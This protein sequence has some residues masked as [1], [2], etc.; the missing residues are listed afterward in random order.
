[1][2]CLALKDKPHFR[3]S[4]VDLDRESPSFTADTLRAIKEEYGC[5][6]RL[7]F[8]MGMDSLENLR[9]WHHPEDIIRLT[10]IIAVSRP[11]FNAD[12]ATLERDLPGISGVT[13]TLTT[14]NIGISSTD[15][16]RRVKQGLSIDGQVPAS[17]GAYIDEYHLYRENR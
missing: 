6:T 12:V 11:G 13:D 10:R 17:V 8:I 2:V 3:V 9:T 15:L 14:V 7:F 16:R 4:R 5:N 1:M